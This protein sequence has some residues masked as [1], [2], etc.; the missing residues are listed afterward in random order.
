MHKVV[1]KGKEAVH[2]AEENNIPMVHADTDEAGDSSEEVDLEA[3]R[4][5]LK[6]HPDRVWLE[7]EATINQGD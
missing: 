4:D 2:Y 7:V 3:A 6:T 5:M 1:L